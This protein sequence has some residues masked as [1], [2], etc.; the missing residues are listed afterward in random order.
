[1]HC[2]SLYFKPLTKAIASA[3]PIEEKLKK[4]GEKVKEALVAFV[5]IEA[6]DDESC[7]E[8][9]I[10]EIIKVGKQ[11]KAECYV[12][13][14]YVH[15]SSN[16][17]RPELALQLLKS[18]EAGLK[19]KK[20]KVVRAPFGWYKE[21]DIN[22]K[23]H[24]LSELSREIKPKI[25]PR[26]EKIRAEEKAGEKEEI[27]KA[28]EA[29]KKASSDW[30]ILDLDGNLHRI[31]LKGEELVG[32]DFAGYEKL[33]K[34]A[35]YEMKKIRAVQQ[36][37]PHVKYMRALEL[38]DYESASDPGH[39]RF[40]PKGRLIK[41]LLEQ[42]VT[43]QMQEYG[44]LEV[45]TPIM[46]DFEHP[47]LKAYL[48]KFPARQ[49]AIITPN[50]KVFL[51]FAACFGQFIMAS[52]MGISY[53]DL[54]LKLYELTRYSFRVE[55]R[56]EL[57]GLR[58]LRAF[59]MPDCHALC[60][61]LEQAKEEM[62]I[63]FALAKK[64][65][66][67]IG[68]D[69]SKD[70]ELGIRLTKDF[71]ESNADFVKELVR[72]FGKPALIEMWSSQYFY[73]IL[74]YELNFVDAL[75]KASALATD[76]IDTGNAKNYGITFIDSDNK[77]KYPIILH[78]SPSGSLERVMYALLEKAYMDEK[79]GQKPSLPFW[80]APIQARLIPVSEKYVEEAID[81]AN[82]LNV[83]SELR[84]DVDDRDLH[85]SKKI[86]EAEKEWIPYIIVIGKKELENGIF[87]VR[88]RKSGEIKELKPSEFREIVKKEQGKMPFRPLPLPMLLSKR[89]NF[90]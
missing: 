74:K 11:V 58:R 63:R 83:H 86:L 69:V 39:F 77:K 90:V 18:I 57:V 28:L 89:P 25:K 64:I 31:K 84:V 3:E 43:S 36:E 8:Q 50:K 82:D 79:L 65:L 23:G 20:L 7:V 49:Y 80:L 88:I 53:K 75:D 6:G 32:F 66:S 81:I 30:F 59:T 41:A 48:H 70:F 27:S 51:R 46:Y 71:W 72:A 15:L 4:E 21:F 14:P 60:K 12:V 13:Y 35:R 38:V 19:K 17:S 16:P 10:D 26:E 37:P 56:G 5:A 68:F 33:E 40:Y 47:A 87:T 76:Q 67:E 9:L 62:R 73:F 22:V 61:D 24:P 44:A 52:H 85:V 54:P 34:F 29:E 2:N 55:Q 42:Y 1:M 78:F 45:E